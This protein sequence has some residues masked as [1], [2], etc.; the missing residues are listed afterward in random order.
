LG[1]LILAAS[2]E[3]RHGAQHD[4]NHP[5]QQDLQPLLVAQQSHS[6]LLHCSGGKHTGHQ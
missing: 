4:Q 1:Q 2:F 3:K 5:M 6:F